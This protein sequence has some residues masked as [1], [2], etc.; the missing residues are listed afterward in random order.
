MVVMQPLLPFT[1]LTK[2][3]REREAKKRI[4]ETTERRKDFALR[5][6][7]GELKERRWKTKIKKENHWK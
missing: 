4:V 6:H 7:D 2:R 1:M 5:T 3:E